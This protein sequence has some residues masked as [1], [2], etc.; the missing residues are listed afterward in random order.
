[1]A[2]ASAVAEVKLDAAKSSS[3]GSNTSWRKGRSSSSGSS[4]D[5]RG[6]RRA[7]PRD[8]QQPVP[9]GMGADSLGLGSQLTRLSSGSGG[10]QVN[11]TCCPTRSL[12]LGTLSV[13]RSFLVAC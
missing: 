12:A 8:D 2:V 4:S 3:S 9:N 5:S 1:M 10:S 7:N 13:A 6:R 11:P